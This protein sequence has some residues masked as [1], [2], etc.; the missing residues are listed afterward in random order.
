MNS[1][2]TA[3]LTILPLAALL[4]GALL[5]FRLALR[6]RGR[7]RLFE[8]GSVVEMPEPAVEAGPGW[9]ALRHWLLLAGYRSPA[10]PTV[11]LAAM[12]A[13]TALGG[14][15]VLLYYFG[16]LA[17]ALQENLALAP[18]GLAETFLPL[19]HLVPWI[20]VALFGSAPWLAV[21]RARRLRVQLVEQDLSLTL[22]MLATL[23]EAGLGF[24]AALAHVL[25]TSVGHRP[26]GRD[27]RSFQSDLIGGRSRIDALRRLA[28]R[29]EISHVSILVSALVQ[30]EQLGTGIAGV[31]RRQADDL[32]DRR[33]EQANAFAMT[34]PVKRMFPLVMCFLPG[35]F[36]WILGPAFVQLFR[37]VDSFTQQGGGF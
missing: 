16:G 33:R 22:E 6:A 36:V 26:L 32:R 24:D 12:A 17:G 14:G 19:A 8:G 23:S 13:G 15:V 3:L 27:L 10:A 37:I 9:N 31:L 18:P 21:R 30:G 4:A 11:F 29:L 35:L 2:Q 34:L 7:A 20:A 28:R 5:L 1:V 25:E